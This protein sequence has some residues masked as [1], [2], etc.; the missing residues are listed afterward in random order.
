MMNYKTSFNITTLLRTQ[1]YERKRIYECIGQNQVIH[2]KKSAMAKSEQ[3]NYMNLFILELY[4]FL[5]IQN[6]FEIKLSTWLGFHL[7]ERDEW[8]DQ[9]KEQNGIKK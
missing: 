3:I 9:L 8:Y 1:I 4:L 7:F 5:S 2:N 6:C